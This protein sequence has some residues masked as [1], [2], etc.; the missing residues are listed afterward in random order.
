MIT[1]KQLRELERHS[2]LPL[3]QVMEN[4]G[5][6]VY[7]EIEKRFKLKGKKIIIFAWHG[8]NSGDGF[9]AAHWL[10]K[11]G[12]QVKVLFLGNEAKLTML[13][14]QKYERIKELIVKSIGNGEI[15][16]ANIIIDAMLG[17]GVKGI[18]QEP[19]A[20]AVDLFNSSK[21]FKVAVDV[22][23]GIN[24]DNGKKTNKFIKAD[25]I[26]TMHDIKLGLLQYK[27]KAIVR[28]VGL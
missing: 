20:S 26:I 22:P 11:A 10:A 9:V 8:N 16:K 14:K 19:L 15:K 21:A 12:A 24:P 25:L 6:A 2:K 4:A 13:T 23:T 3:E 27:D 7:E 5:K 1:T 17:T 18:I 28:K